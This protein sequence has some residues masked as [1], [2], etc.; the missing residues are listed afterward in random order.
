MMSS[1][2]IVVKP[3]GDEPPRIEAGSTVIGLLFG[4]LIGALCAVLYRD[5]QWEA[6]AIARQVGR[7][8]SRDGEFE[9]TFKRK[10]ECDR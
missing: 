6:E 5:S 10:C 9:W 2:D 3:T 8:D 1:S 7:Y 4:L